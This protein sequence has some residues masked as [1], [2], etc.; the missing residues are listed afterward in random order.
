M[1]AICG[2]SYTPA[3]H[4][5]TDA[6]KKDVQRVSLWSATTTGICNV[7]YLYRDHR[8]PMEKMA[9]RATKEPMEKRAKRA[10]K[11]P[12]DL[13][14]KRAKKAKKEPMDS[15]EPMDQLDLRDKREIP[16]DDGW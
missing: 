16:G 9:K 14:E 1:H 13:R 4:L 15:M 11:E 3:T 12:M 10:T 8:E 6:T 5:S 2:L 7:V